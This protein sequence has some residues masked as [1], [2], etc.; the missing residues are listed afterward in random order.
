MKNEIMYVRWQRNTAVVLLIL[1]IIFCLMGWHKYKETKIVKEGLENLLG[2]MYE[3]I[4]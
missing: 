2:N 1:T 3:T 4:E